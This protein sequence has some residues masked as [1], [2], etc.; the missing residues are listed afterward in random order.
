MK[1]I[2]NAMLLK[3]HNCMVTIQTLQV[4]VILW[5]QPKNPKILWQQ[6]FNLLITGHLNSSGAQTELKVVVLN[7]NCTRLRKK[8]AAAVYSRISTKNSITE[9][10]NVTVFS[11][12]AYLSYMCGSTPYSTSS[13]ILVC[14][15]LCGLKA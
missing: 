1:L 15:L 6:V 5:F 13:L 12:D 4:G 10:Q 8:Y 2:W 9:D 11:S 14:I 3:V 7:S